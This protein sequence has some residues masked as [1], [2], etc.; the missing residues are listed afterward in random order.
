MAHVMADTARGMIQQKYKQIPVKIE[1]VKDSDRAAF[2]N[3]SGI[4]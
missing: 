1:A 3:G 4:M 2:G